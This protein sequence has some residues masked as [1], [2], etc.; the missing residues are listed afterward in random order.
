M[1]YP[2]YPPW[3]PVVPPM[4]SGF[5]H[6][7]RW[8]GLV[9]TDRRH[10]RARPDFWKNLDFSIFDFLDRASVLGVLDIALLIPEVW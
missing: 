9:I 2:W 6:G 1:G 4:G 10:G 3:D 8:R 7:P 5:P